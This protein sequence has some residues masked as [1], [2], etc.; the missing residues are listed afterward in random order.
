MRITILTILFS[1]GALFYLYLN[2][3]SENIQLVTPNTISFIALVY[4]INSCIKL[5]YYIYNNNLKYMTFINYLM[6]SYFIYQYMFQNNFITAVHFFMYVA[7]SNLYK[8]DL[9][10]HGHIL[11]KMCKYTLLPIFLSYLYYKSSSLILA[12]LY[13]MYVS[14][15]YYRNNQ[16]I[17]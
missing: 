17:N 7:L 2:K 16:I 12:L 4:Y 14:Y 3:S 5:F 8:L 10:G 11:G 15:I 1:Y 13:S 9:A 6:D